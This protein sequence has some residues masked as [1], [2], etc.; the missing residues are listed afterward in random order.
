MDLDLQT[1]LDLVYD[2]AESNNMLFNSGKFQHLQYGSCN[3]DGCEYSSPNNEPIGIVLEVKD[4][5]IVMNSTGS[6]ENHINERS[7]KSN[8]MAGWLIR[9]FRTRNPGPMMTLFI[10]LVRPILEYC[11]QLWS[12]KKLSQIRNI[13]SVQ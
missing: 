9:T 3:F 7:K 11:C 4:L 8:Q 1:D 12:P 10:S 5:G 6:F 2:W 13:E